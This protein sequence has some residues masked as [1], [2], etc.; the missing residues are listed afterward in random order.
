M[1]LDDF[2]Q[3]IAELSEKAGIQSIAFCIV[4]PGHTTRLG[5]ISKNGHRQW[6]LKMQNAMWEV[7]KRD[8]Y[9]AVD[10]G[11]GSI[12][13]AGVHHSRCCPVCGNHYHDEFTCFCHTCGRNTLGF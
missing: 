2:M 8:G 11:S 10:I 5:H 1:E 12:D 4:S 9:T 3:Q 7:C 6:G 13:D